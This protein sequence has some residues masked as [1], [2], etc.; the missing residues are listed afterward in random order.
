MSE[1]RNKSSRERLAS[2]K[3]EQPPTLVVLSWRFKIDFCKTKLKANTFNS[4]K[5]GDHH[6]YKARL[7]LL[8][9]LLEY[10]A[11]FL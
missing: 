10:T 4:R 11:L 9:R 3:L 2:P 6:V 7:N 1:R 5:K 8:C